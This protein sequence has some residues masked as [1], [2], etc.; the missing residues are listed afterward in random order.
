MKM[1]KEELTEILRLHGL[2]VE[3]NPE[4]KRADLSG[5]DLYG[6]DL[7]RAKLSRANL[8][9]ADL[10]GANLSRANLY[11]ANLSGADLYGADLSG[12][13]LHGAD[14]YGA[15]L[16]R[17]K[18]DAITIAR[19][20]IVPETGAFEAYKKLR[21]G[22]I[23]RL[24]IPADAKRSNAT[25]RKCRA[26]KAIVLEGEEDSIHDSSVHYA[27]GMTVQ[28]DTWEPDRWVECGGGIHFFITRAEAE[29]YTV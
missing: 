4:G 9:G 6:E 8:Y 26:E 15:D 1:T 7:S 13:D 5:A 29:A 10:S 12:A 17:A 28:C 14:L 3:G 25:G 24:L 23:A 27:P 2:W 16:S 18:L 11:E 19:L 20:S 22:T 21:H